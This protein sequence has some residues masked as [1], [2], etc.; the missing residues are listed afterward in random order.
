MSAPRYFNHILN[1]F[2]QEHFFVVK[3][4]FISGSL[5]R[6]ELER[7]I[8]AKYKIDVGSCVTE[9]TLDHYLIGVH[10]FAV[11]EAQ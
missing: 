1:K 7:V 9:L 10:S 11:E 8:S 4:I 2:G 3:E 6:S 5:T